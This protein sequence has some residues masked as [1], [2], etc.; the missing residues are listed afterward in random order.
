M[1]ELHQFLPDTETLIALAAAAAV[2]IAVLAVWSSFIDRDPLVARARGL[3]RRHEDLRRNLLGPDRHAMRAGRQGAITLIGRILARLN[4][5]KTEQAAKSSFRLAQA[6]LRSKEA[7]TIFLFAKL[8][9]PLLLAWLIAVPVM[10]IES[11]ELPS[12]VPLL[13]AMSVVLAGSYVP[14]LVVRNMVRKRQAAVR[15]ALPDAL[16]LLV[17][18]AEAGLGLDAAIKRVAA[19]LA[20]SAAELAD[21]FALAAI[22]LGF[23]P[24]RRM[25]LDN[26]VR[27]TDLPPIRAVVNTLTQSEKYGTPLAHSLR[28][29][30]AEFRTERMLKAEEK[31]A[32]L[33]AT[34]TVPLVVFILPTLFVV[35]LGPA[36]LSA[37]DGLRGL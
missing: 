16:D 8:V 5:L 4:L 18:C 15:K 9:L 14:E 33:P 12:T 10:S 23:L 34:L 25:A 31:A 37:L 24:E 22:E 36:V 13:V 2:L 32:K 26:L 3:V 6:G 17:I 11:D 28:V 29:L 19:E 30:A 1:K 27:R 21:E 7:T 35:L 20:A